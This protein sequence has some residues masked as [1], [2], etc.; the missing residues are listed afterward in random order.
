M[1]PPPT[2]GSQLWSC[3]R[4]GDHEEAFQVAYT[5]RVCA[6]NKGMSFGFMSCIRIQ[7]RL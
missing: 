6:Q 1:Q 4:S 5:Q 7:S 3:E 2:E